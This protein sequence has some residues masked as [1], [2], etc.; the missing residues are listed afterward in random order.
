MPTDDGR[1]KG[2]AVP[3]LPWRPERPARTWDVQ[4]DGCAMTRESLY[5]KVMTYWEA[6]GG[7]D[8]DQ[9]HDRAVRQWRH[10]AQASEFDDTRG[11][12]SYG[13]ALKLAEAIQFVGGADWHIEVV[14]GTVDA[15]R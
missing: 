13:H 8:A 14:E 11:F 7:G 9:R 10:I 6:R 1:I 3:E 12:W 5:R 15:L 4:V 2:I